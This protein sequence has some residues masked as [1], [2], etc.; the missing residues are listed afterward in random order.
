M[1]TQL[2]TWWNRDQIQRDHDKKMM[3]ELERY[4]NALAE[5]RAA[6]LVVENELAETKDEVGVFR[7]K[8][9]ADKAKREGTEPWVEIK[10]ADY[11]EIKGIHIELDWNE[12]FIQYLKDS[13]LKAKDDEAIVQ[14]WL[15]YLYQDLIDKLEQKVVDNSDKPRINDFE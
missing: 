6:K 9:A 8:D 12:A 3:D 10:S 11:S 7:A 4:S 15:A 1:F 13:G 14:K 2:K 5:E